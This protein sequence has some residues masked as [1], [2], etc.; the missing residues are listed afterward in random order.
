MIA[1]NRRRNPSS[2]SVLIVVVVI[3]E[4][5]KNNASF[6]YVW[7]STSNIIIKIHPLIFF[8]FSI[9]LLC[10]PFVSIIQTEI[11][12]IEEICAQQLHAHIYIFNNPDTNVSTD[13]EIDIHW[14]G[15]GHVILSESIT[16]RN[17]TCGLA[18]PVS[19]PTSGSKDKVCVL[20]GLNPVMG[21]MFLKS[22]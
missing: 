7:N 19:Y 21:Q 8:H 17:W 10:I 1:S 16:M 14:T 12:N 4:W 6:R 2:V 22:K 5:S 18:R 9:I 13:V 20:E 3:T 15:S 11:P